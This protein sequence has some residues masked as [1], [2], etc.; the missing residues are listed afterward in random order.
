MRRCV[1]SFLGGQLLFVYCLH[2]FRLLEPKDRA[3]VEIDVL[4]E[5]GISARKFIDTKLDIFRGDHVAPVEEKDSA[6][7]IY[8]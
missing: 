4:F 3:H 1:R 8:V 5:R 6:S 2:F 7:E